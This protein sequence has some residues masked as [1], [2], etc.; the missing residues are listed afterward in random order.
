MKVD[1][2]NLTQAKAKRLLGPAARAV[3]RAN[4]DFSA[5]S[6][7]DAASERAEQRLLAACE[8]EENLR[9]FALTGEKP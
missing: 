2:N 3:K 8:L 5:V 6:E 9:V 1:W 4:E 7:D